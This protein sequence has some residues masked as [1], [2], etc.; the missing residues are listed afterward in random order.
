MKQL[1]NKKTELITWLLFLISS[2]LLYFIATNYSVFPS[3]YKAPLLLAIIALICIS[4]IIT[5]LAKKSLRYVA[6]GINVLLSVFM[7][8][9]LIL[10]PNIEKRVRNI[11]K[12]VR[13]DEA[14]ISIY[15]KTSQYKESLIEYSNPTFIIQ[16]RNYN[17]TK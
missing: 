14:V 15:S 7:I 13:V 3:K 4:G 5:V 8:T 12:D 1:K 11:F 9:G 6:I 2:L 10:L 17:N 16:K